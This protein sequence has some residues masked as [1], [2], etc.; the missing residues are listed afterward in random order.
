MM[1]ILHKFGACIMVAGLVFIMA[2]G[3]NIHRGPDGTCIQVN[4]VHGVGGGL[5]FCG[6]VLS[7]I[8]AFAG[9]SSS[10]EPNAAADRGRM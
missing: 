10:A 9:R 8:A 5:I 4:L 6:M 7:F 2:G 3:M 1:R